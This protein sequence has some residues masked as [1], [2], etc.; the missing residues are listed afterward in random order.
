MLIDTRKSRIP[1]WILWV[2]GQT[3]LVTLA[4]ITLDEGRV[5]QYQKLL[6]SKP[7][8]I[9]VRVEATEVNHLWDASLDDVWWQMYGEEAEKRIEALR[10]NLVK[11]ERDSLRAAFSS[12]W[13]GVANY[14]KEE[15]SSHDLASI[16]GETRPWLRRRNDSRTSEADSSTFA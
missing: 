8:N 10:G 2:T 11:Q 14:F 5:R 15:I 9:V 3:G 12:L 7:E 16:M 13:V 1:A 4:A 6:A